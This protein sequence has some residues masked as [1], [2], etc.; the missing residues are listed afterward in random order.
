MPLASVLQIHGE[1]FI[2]DALDPFDTQRHLHARTIILASTCTRYNVVD[3]ETAHASKVAQL[4]RH[5]HSAV[6]TY[7]SAHDFSVRI[8]LAFLAND[9][10]GWKWS[11]PERLI[12]HWHER[13][14]DKPISIAY[15]A[16]IP[17]AP[18]APEQFRQWV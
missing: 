2:D 16:Q 4:F 18:L 17:C 9:P 10:S 7:A 13:I 6:T 3:C 11:R 15:S 1:A 14:V 5:F 8:L 12:Q